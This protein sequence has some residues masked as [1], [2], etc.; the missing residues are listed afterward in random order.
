MHALSLVPCRKIGVIG[1]PR[2]ACVREHQDALLVIHEALC[3]GE[4]GGAGPRLGRKPRAAI[5]FG[6]FDDTAI[7]PRHFRDLLRAEVMED[8]IERGL[9]WGK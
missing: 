5:G 7:A 8:L 3:L 4:I 9:H 1:A 2:A 6:L